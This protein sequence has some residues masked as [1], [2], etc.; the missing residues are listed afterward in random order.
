[1]RQAKL[2]ELKGLIAGIDEAGRGP[3]AGP[4]A[5]AAVILHPDRP[6]EGLEDSKKLSAAR[7]DALADQIQTQA[8][9]WSVAWADPA[10]IDALNILAATLLAMRRAILGLP[11][12]PGGV[13]VDGNRLPNLSFGGRRVAGEAIVGGDAK[14]AEISAAS[15]IAK[16]TRDRMMVELD[17]IYPC[18]EFA[19][20][21]GYGTEV[22]RAR[23][24][25]FGPC[26]EHRFTFAPLR[27]TS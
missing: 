18:Y 24:R 13:R 5:A 1:M 22:H 11:V 19:R 3:L 9:A 17:R 2:F 23:L 25:E 4:V 6:I 8:L 14:V 12:A 21:K 10:E 16:T 27:T 26:R 15:I 7:R 20:H